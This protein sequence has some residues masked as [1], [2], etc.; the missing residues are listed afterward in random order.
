MEHSQAATT[1][2][3]SVVPAR[4]PWTRQDLA[5]FF[6]QLPQ[7]SGARNLMQNLDAVTQHI[8]LHVLTQCPEYVDTVGE[9]GLKACV[10][11]N[12]LTLLRAAQLLSGPQSRSQEAFLWWW[13]ASVGGYLVHREKAALEAN[14]QGLYQGLEHYLDRTEVEP[15]VDLVSNMYQEALGLQ[16]KVHS[17][18][19]LQTEHLSIEGGQWQPV[20]APAAQDDDVPQTMLD[21]FKDAPQTAMALSDGISQHLPQAVQQALH[22]VMPVKTQK[23]LWTFIDANLQHGDEEAA[24][25]K[26]QVL[27]DRS[28]RSQSCAVLLNEWRSLLVRLPQ[29]MTPSASAYWTDT[30]QRGLEVIAQVSLGRI[31][32]AAS[33]RVAGEIA[34]HLMQQRVV[35]E[36]SP[37]DSSAELS[38]EAKCKRDLGFLLEVMGQIWVQSPPSLAALN[39]SRYVVQNVAP[40]VDY[41]GRVWRLVWLKLQACLW[42]DLNAQEQ[43]QCVLW[44]AQLQDMCADLHLTRPLGE[45]VFH[46]VAPV[47][48]DPDIAEQ[49]WRNALGGLISAAL[50]SEHAPYPGSVLAQRLLLSSPVFAEMD[51]PRWQSIHTSLADSFAELL[52]APIVARLEQVQA[53]ISHSL[54]RLSMCDSLASVQTTDKHQALRLRFYLALPDLPYLAHSWQIHLWAKLSSPQSGKRGLSL[55]PADRLLAEL[56]HWALP[57]VPALQAHFERYASVTDA[58]QLLALPTAASAVQAT[59]QAPESGLSLTDEYALHLRYLALYSEST[60]LQPMLYRH[61]LFLEPQHSQALQRMRD[62]CGSLP[63]SHWLAET[64]TQAEQYLLKL[65]I[66]RRLLNPKEDLAQA[67]FPVLK[68]NPCIDLNFV[69]QHIGVSF[70]GLLPHLD[71][72]QWYHDHVAVF[73]SLRTR[74][75]NTQLWAPLVQHLSKAWTPA[76][77]KL[78]LAAVKQLARPLASTP[79]RPRLSVRHFSLQGAVWQQVFQAAT[80]SPALQAL[81]QALPACRDQL[82]TTLYQDLDTFCQHWEHTGDIEA[83]WEALQPSWQAQLSQQSTTAL[84][85]DWQAALPILAQH[86]SPVQ[87]AYWWHGLQKGLHLLAQTGLGVRLQQQADDIAKQVAQRLATAPQGFHDLGLSDPVLAAAKCRR[88]QALLLTAVGEMLSQQSASLAALNIGRYLIQNIVP[89]VNYNTGAWQLVWLMWQEASADRLDAL[90]KQ[91]LR[92]CCE[93]LNGLSE[94]FSAMYALELFNVAHA[95][96]D[97]TATDEDNLA[98]Q[99]RLDTLGGLLCAAAT[100]DSAPLSGGYLL[101]RLVLSSPLFAHHTAASWQEVQAELAQALAAIESSE[102]NQPLQQRYNQIVDVLFKLPRLAEWQ[103]FSGDDIEALLLSA[104]PEA[105][106]TWDLS[107]YVSQQIPPSAILVQQ[108]NGWNGLQPQQAQALAQTYQSIQAFNYQQALSGGKWYQ[109]HQP[110]TLPAPAVPVLQI[111]LCHLS[112]YR[113][114]STLPVSAIRWR[115]SQTWQAILLLKLGL[116]KDSLLNFAQLWQQQ[117]AQQPHLA[118]LG[119][120]ITQHL[121][122]VSA[123]HKLLHLNL[124]KPMSRVTI[125]S[126]CSADARYT[127]KQMG[128]YLCGEPHTHS[129]ET[130]YAQHVG[131]FVKPATRQAELQF[132]MKLSKAWGD[133]FDAEEQAAIAPLFAAIQKSLSLATSPT[134]IEWTVSR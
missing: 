67:L 108:S 26:A 8:S 56:N 96:V 130:W 6:S 49:D 89:F 48:G 87:V 90:E 29:W 22:D 38:A 13:D 33:Q 42:P 64:A 113:S 31:L 107:Q 25:G 99:A 75:R 12:R 36:F 92:Q 104:A 43:T 11:D 1:P 116:H 101:Q 118:Q 94:H 83:A 106:L 114:S 21:W 97:N 124:D 126:R 73:V 58:Q 20:F 84:H 10:R 82:S 100:P 125:H 95:Q 128:A 105:E 74:Q 127:L 76:E 85:R 121:S 59:P 78:L 88:D 133:T 65:G 91:A 57:E 103:A 98:Q 45:A 66:A 120:Y 132:F 61:L 28:L 63:S 17:A 51:A 110:D 60:Q 86:L 122:A 70:T 27:M 93:Q 14:L 102:L 41:P 16:L 40:F 35:R 123:G 112:L 2:S 69:L 68:V 30:L 46:Q 34:A 47:F 81:Q 7:L 3:P 53:S 62:W 18:V 19:S 4:T 80:A 23:I 44:V 54:L 119:E 50:T 134:D 117:H 32:Q 72:A 115:I 9:A 24:W 39:I 77:Q 71:L 131:R 79:K 55:N 52:S 129:I 5:H 37:K 109:R 111:L 15:M